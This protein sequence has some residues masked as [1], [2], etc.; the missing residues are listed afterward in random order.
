MTSRVAQI[1]TSSTD[2]FGPHFG[3]KQRLRQKSKQRSSSTKLLIEMYCVKCGIESQGGSYIYTTGNVLP[4]EP[5]GDGSR[6]ACSRVNPCPGHP[7]SHREDS[8]AYSSR[9]LSLPPSKSPLEEKV[10]GE[11]PLAF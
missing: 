2:V 4:Q 5:W 1:A 9:P 11:G 3:W 7:L 6:I 8:I 10:R